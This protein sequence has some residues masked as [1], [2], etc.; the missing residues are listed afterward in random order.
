MRPRKDGVA[1]RNVEQ[2][3][4]VRV[5]EVEVYYALSDWPVS[6]T[7]GEGVTMWLGMDAGYDDTRR[8]ERSVMTGAGRW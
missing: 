1:R 2:V 4:F 6:E 3:R 8:N 5:L 7:C